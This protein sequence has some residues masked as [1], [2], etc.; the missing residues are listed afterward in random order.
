MGHGHILDSHALFVRNLAPYSQGL[1]IHLSGGFLG[2]GIPHGHVHGLYRN[3]RACA[4]VSGF[5]GCAAL[6][7]LGGPNWLD[8]Y[9]CRHAW[10][11]LAYFALRSARSFILK[12]IWKSA[13]LGALFQFGIWNTLRAWGRLLLTP[14]RGALGFTW[15]TDDLVYHQ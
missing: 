12:L 6:V 13:P 5:N 7:Y 15:R 1:P 4:Q 8:S 3:I 14:L 11:S 9:L 2:H 10:I